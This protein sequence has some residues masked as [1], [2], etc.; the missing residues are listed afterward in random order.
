[1][2]LSIARPLLLPPTN[3]ATHAAATRKQAPRGTSLSR[4]LLACDA[5]STSAPLPL[6]FSPPHSSLL[7]STSD[8]ATHH[9]SRERSCA[10]NA[11]SRVARERQPIDT[12]L[13]PNP[14]RPLALV[15]VHRRSQPWRIEGPHPRPP[16]HLVWL[17]RADSRRRSPA[18]GARSMAREEAEA[19]AEAEAAAAATATAASR[20]TRRTTLLLGHRCAARLVTVLDVRTRS[21]THTHTRTRTRT[22]T[23]AAICARRASAARSRADHRLL[24]CTGPRDTRGSRQ[25]HL[26][27]N[28]EARRRSNTS[29][30][31][32]SG[33][34]QERH[35]SS[36]IIIV[37]VVAIVAIYINVTKHRR[38]LVS[39]ALVPFSA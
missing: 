34:A 1:M 39:A 27:L 31:R 6:V 3:A 17:P 10:R 12:S 36:V 19:E 7:P 26:Q 14:S 2:G 22:H 16:L 29:G 15:V 33:A 8:A 13:P 25:R 18:H 5:I 35:P 28:L 11:R 9:R 32:S 37:V 21:L 23:G 24:R 38:G 30:T 20:S 4:A